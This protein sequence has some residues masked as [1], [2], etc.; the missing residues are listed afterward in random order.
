MNPTEQIMANKGKLTRKT[1]IY[2]IVAVATMTL[3]MLAPNA[4]I[5][6]LAIVST[7]WFSGYWFLRL[8]IEDI[9]EAAGRE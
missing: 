5:V 8:N 2:G 3:A 6:L 4:G 7:L 9:A 1:I